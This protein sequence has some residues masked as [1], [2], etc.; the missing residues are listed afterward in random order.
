M[1]IGCFVDKDHPPSPDEMKGALGE[2]S[3]LWEKLLQFIEE[4]YHM[5]GEVSFGGK[6]YGWNIWYRKGGKSLVSLYPQ[7]E[8]IVAQ[9]VLGKDQVAKALELSLGE[10]VGKMVRETPQLHD[11]EWLFIPVT[12]E[13]DVQDVEQLLLVKKRPVNKRS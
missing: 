2:T 1:S 9:V 10:K 5:P 12:T 11:G 8:S 13:R 3:P 6:N 7:E 4:T